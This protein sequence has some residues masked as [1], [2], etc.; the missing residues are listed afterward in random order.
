[1][2]K[3]KVQ[4]GQHLLLDNV[5]WKG[6]LRVLRIFDER[7]GWR[8][9]YDRGVLEIMT[10]S[11]MHERLK[12][13]LGRLIE[14]L[15][16]ELGVAIAGFGS[17]TFKR[18]RRKRGLEAD[19]CYWIANA[20]RVHGKDEIDLRTDPP[21]DLAL[22]V[23]VSRS[24]LNRMTIYAALGVPEVW[25]FDGQTL[26]FH[27]L[28]PNQQYV[29]IPSSQAFPGLTP[30]DISH[31]LALRSQV[32]ENDLIRQFRAWVQQQVAAGVLSRPA[33]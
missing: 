12:H 31:F 15:S 19:E 14:A 10:L 11:P 3:V 33:P 29:A 16:E 1:M 9:T 22:E 27:S 24:A 7:P 6:Y 23:E 2:G 18:R 21:P 5:D 4:A 30:D 26:T 17:M 13:L 32:H 28:D 20:A 8:V 25:R